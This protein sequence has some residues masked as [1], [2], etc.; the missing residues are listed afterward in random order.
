VSSQQIQSFIDAYRRQENYYRD[1]AQT[2]E[3]LLESQL[4]AQGVRALV[5]ARSKSVE[6]LRGKLEQRN[7][8]KSY[9]THD[10]IRADIRDLAG[11]R[12]ALYFPSDITSV[13]SIMEA[14]FR[15][16]RRDEL[17]KS[18][19]HPYGRFPGYCALHY[20]VRLKPELS[21]KLDARYLQDPVE[22]QVATVFMHAWAEVEHDLRYKPTTG[23]LSAEE[24]LILEQLNGLALTAE[25]SLRNLQAAI[26]RRAS[27]KEAAL[28][29]H[30][31]LAALLSKLAEDRSPELAKMPMGR[32][33]VLYYFLAEL[34]KLSVTDVTTL[35][36]S[37]T[38]ND[39]DR[40]TVDG[41]VDHLLAED[42]SR[43]ETFANARESAGPGN[44]YEPMGESEDTRGEVRFLRLWRLAEIA[45]A[46]LLP[47]QTI[48]IK[49]S[50]VANRRELQ[51][52]LLRLGTPEATELL[53]ILQSLDPARYIRNSFV[54][55]GMVIQNDL[56]ESESRKLQAYITKA[57][58]FI[59]Q[60][61]R[62]LIQNLLRSL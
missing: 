12:V 55:G 1:L 37:V 41:L 22:V 31:E 57:L 18:D 51:S 35:F 11:V 43:A 30:F 19:T 59:D 32:A 21:E 7:A 20:C 52:H 56:L 9:K 14:F 53:N 10:E 54:H 28:E 42:D 13:E 2:V 44:P 4:D 46:A 48:A 58:D 5:T 36:N 3:R 40:S 61:Q 50:F 24:L 49:R 15:I 16:D 34:G 26:T 8:A 29:N 6:R 25:T 39:E 33:D 62:L 23:V 38:Y 27:E 45:S 60:D 17:P 47:E